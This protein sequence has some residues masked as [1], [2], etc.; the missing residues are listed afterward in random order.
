[1][2]GR[3]SAAPT[4]QSQEISTVIQAASGN[5]VAQ[6]TIKMKVFR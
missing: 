1:M 4:K 6:R 3:S 2:H 5:L